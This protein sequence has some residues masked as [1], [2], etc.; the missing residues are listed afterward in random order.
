MK[1]IN[2]RLDLS[3]DGS[4]YYGWQ[5]QKKFPTIQETLEKSLGS[6]L[7]EKIGVIGIGR[8]DAGAHAL[9]YTANFKTTRLSFPF[10]KLK[11]ILNTRLPQDTRVLKAEQVSPEFHSRFDACARE[12]VYI[13]LTPSFFKK[14]TLVNKM[15]PFFYRY[16]HVLEE[17]PDMER[18]KTIVKIFRGEHSFKH[19]SI[20][21][22]RDMNFI[23]RIHYFRVKNLGGK[24]VFFIKGNGFLNG[25]IRSIVSTSLNFAYGKLNEEI[26]SKALHNEEPIPSKYR[27]L[28]P[29]SG[30][31]FKRGFFNIPEA[32]L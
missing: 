8:T 18:L 30:L 11:D 4:K 23:R 5:K 29:A 27:V 2:I 24:I 13:A 19:F 26:I 3:Y 21:Y 14:D 16:F 25:M 10:V 6:I 9:C 15:K 22:G 17:E 7:N 28:V 32:L 31:Y 1:I 12:Y 20:G